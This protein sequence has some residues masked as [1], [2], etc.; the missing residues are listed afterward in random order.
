MADRNFKRFAKN[1]AVGLKH[2]GMVLTYVDDVKV[3]TVS[4][5]V[6]IMSFKGSPFQSGSG[7]VA[8]I[9]VTCAKLTEKNKPKGFI[10]WV[11]NGIE[12]EVRLYERL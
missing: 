9:L 8:E 3:R 11:S 1:Q 4:M 7:E 5:N 10:Q 12:I 2:V 6:M